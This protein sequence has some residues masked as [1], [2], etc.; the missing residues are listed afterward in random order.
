MSP[1][2]P[3]VFNLTASPEIEVLDIIEIEDDDLPDEDF[4]RL[5]SDTANWP[6][7][8]L[9]K[10]GE[11]VLIKP[12]WNMVLDIAETP[13][14]RLLKVYGRLTFSDE[15]DVHLHA[16]HVTIRSG[17]FNIGSVYEPY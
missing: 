8:E 17:E 3:V 16:K 6:N 4:E 7:G 13:V 10:E 12:Q 9:P 2:A 11:D 14:I 15:M 1:K 5:W